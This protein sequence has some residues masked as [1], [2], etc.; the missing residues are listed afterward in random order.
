MSDDVEVL[1]GKLSYTTTKDSLE[2]KVGSVM[3]QTLRGFKKL[4]SILHSHMN[5]PRP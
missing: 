3:E 1:H 5:K 2:S 4:E